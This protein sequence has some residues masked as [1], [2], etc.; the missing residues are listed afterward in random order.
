MDSVEER[1]EFLPT[2][3]SLVERLKDLEDQAVWGEFFDLYR[4][5]I[6]GVAMKSGF[7]H[8]EAQDLV[9]ETIIFVAKNI[10]H[11]RNDPSYGSFKSWLL[12]TTYSRMTDLRRR[13]EVRNRELPVNEDPPL[14]DLEHLWENEW[15]E[16]TRDAALESLKRQIPP[17]QYQVFF[18]NVIKE[19]SATETARIVGISVAQV[20]LLKHRLARLY[21]ECVERAKLQLDSRLPAMAESRKTQGAIATPGEQL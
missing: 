6:Y 9:Q 19:L 3:K 18:L 17:K 2:R 21:G 12:T 5:L 7:S 11:F 4:K 20:Y 15:R 14:S 8:A 10:A 13:A 1:C 16:A